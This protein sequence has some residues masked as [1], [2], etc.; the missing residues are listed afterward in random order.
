[1]HEW[2]NSAKYGWHRRRIIRLL[3][4]RNII[5]MGVFFMRGVPGMA[6]LI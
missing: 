5:G 3:S 6:K 1:M 2:A 4:L